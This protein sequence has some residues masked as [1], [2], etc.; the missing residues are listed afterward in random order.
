MDTD[1]QE[2]T[3]KDSIFFMTRWWITFHI[4]DWQ[5][6][7]TPEAWGGAYETKV[8][9]W[10]RRR[11][12]LQENMTN[13]RKTGHWSFI[14]THEDAGKARQKQTT[15]KQLSNWKIF[16]W[17]TTWGIVRASRAKAW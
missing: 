4:Y 8:Y 2:E 10:R 17:K 5:R 12:N 14:S 9:L 15:G 1:K 13:I 6:G 3:G 16:T 11:M 7:I